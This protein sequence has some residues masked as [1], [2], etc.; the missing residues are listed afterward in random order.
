MKHGFSW[1][2]K[3]GNMTCAIND[4]AIASDNTKRFLYKGSFGNIEKSI[5]MIPK[6][7]DEVVW[8]DQKTISN[9][10]NNEYG[11]EIECDAFFTSEKELT[12]VVKPADCVIAIVYAQLEDQPIIGFIHAGWR[13]VNLGLPRKAI[14]Y[15]IKDLGVDVG[16]I[17]I[18]VTPHLL[19]KS[20]KTPHIN[21]LGN[22]SNWQDSIIKID[23]G[24]SV[25]M[26]KATINQLIDAGV[27]DENIEY[28]QVDTYENAL[29]GDT[30]SFRAHINEVNIPNG[31]YIIAIR[32]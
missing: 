16:T 9:L 31:R 2:K 14:K 11:K 4:S 24:Y 19:A 15:L 10:E 29:K 18:G 12:L 17:E 25:D 28:Y 26:G 1:G 13:G 20:F 32:L 30:F 6:H 27:K 22:L 7:Q 3:W 23:D 8:I 5:N 21:K